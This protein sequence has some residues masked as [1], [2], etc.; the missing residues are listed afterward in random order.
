LIAYGP[1]LMFGT[2]IAMVGSSRL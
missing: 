1:F 2:M